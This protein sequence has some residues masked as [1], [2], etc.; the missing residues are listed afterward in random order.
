LKHHK[1]SLKHYCKNILNKTETGKSTINE[2]TGKK[3]YI[4]ISEK[5]YQKFIDQLPKEYDYYQTKDGTIVQF[6]QPLYDNFKNYP[7]HD[8]RDGCERN[9]F[10]KMIFN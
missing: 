4:P 10:F 5:E 2:Y 6:L 3:P 1:K 7:N 8:Q 9:I